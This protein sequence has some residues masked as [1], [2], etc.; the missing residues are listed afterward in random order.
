ARPT[1]PTPMTEAE[2]L[3]R[4]RHK[5]SREDVVGRQ[6][7]RMLAA[8]ADVL[9]ERGYAN[10][11]VAAVIER[12]GVS[13]ETF[14]QQFASKQDCFIAA[15]EAVVGAVIA[16]VTARIVSGDVAGLAAVR[17]PIVELAAATLVSPRS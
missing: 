3:P 12:A 4:G 8:L 10:T 14:Y 16:L 11:P 6:R 7:E 17:A 13:R 15:F 9:T 2:R 5:L 1:R